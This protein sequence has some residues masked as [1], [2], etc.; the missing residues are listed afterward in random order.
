M[1]ISE[2]LLCN[3]MQ[4]TYNKEKKIWILCKEMLPIKRGLNLLK[5]NF[6]LKFKVFWG[7]KLMKRDVVATCTFCSPLFKPANNSWFLEGHLSG[8]GQFWPDKNPVW[9]DKKF[10]TLWR[11]Q[12]SERVINWHIWTHFSFFLWTKLSRDALSVQRTRPCQCMRD[13]FRLEDSLSLRWLINIESLM[14]PF[15]SWQTR[16][17]LD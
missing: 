3:M 4:V 5:K 14:L 1:V 8:Q 15:G 12:I 16:K 2:T 6:S 11:N 9:L 17:I 10:K 13:I 7:E